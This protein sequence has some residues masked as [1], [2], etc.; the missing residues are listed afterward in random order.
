MFQSGIPTTEV[1]S[2]RRAKLPILFFCSPSAMAPRHRFSP[3]LTTMTLSVL[4]SLTIA[5]NTN[6][7][8]LTPYVLTSQP[9]YVRTALP[10]QRAE[11][12]LVVQL[13]Q[14]P[15][16]DDGW[17]GS[18]PVGVSG[19][20]LGWRHDG[21]GSLGWSVTETDVNGMSRNYW[22]A[23]PLGSSR[24]SV[25]L[26]PGLDPIDPPLPRPSAFFT[27]HTDADPDLELTISGASEASSVAWELFPEPLNVSVHAPGDPLSPAPPY[28]VVNW[29]VLS[30]DAVLSDEV[31]FTGTGELNG[32]VLNNV[33]LGEETSVIQATLDAH[34]R[35]HVRWTLHAVDCHQYQLCA[36]CAQ[37]TQCGWCD[38][39]C[40]FG[41]ETHGPRDPTHVRCLE[42]AGWQW[43][44]QSCSTGTMEVSLVT[45]GI[46]LGGT[47]LAGLCWSG[48]RSKTPVPGY[49]SVALGVGSDWDDARQ[50]TIEG[51]Y[52]LSKPSS[53][54]SLTS[55]PLTRSS[56]VAS[57][58][59]SGTL[60]SN[61]SSSLGGAPSTG[62]N[63]SLSSPTYDPWRA[64]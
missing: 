12:D 27:M 61:S 40:I 23:G 56:S 60:R 16:N 53:S 47:G 28:T 52:A 48:I 43:V 25:S 45:I 42:E 54:V 36:D 33:T 41:D 6:R 15:C 10:Y 35:I 55:A 5:Q 20:M 59:Q 7:T 49:A 17:E 19:V 21:A 50:G 1:T 29:E 2:R 32:R 30:G 38:G 4:I 34:A 24:V 13:T 11:P 14:G 26:H 51:P 58:M 8:C 31:T 46:L 22:T 18:E 64:V 57:S 44:P 63:K 39:R 62:G 3:V 9:P 37:H